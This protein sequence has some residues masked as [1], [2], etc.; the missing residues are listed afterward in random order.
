MPPT[1]ALTQTKRPGVLIV[2]ERRERDRLN[3]WLA[4]YASTYGIPM[5]DYHTFLNEG[6]PL[7]FFMYQ[8]LTPAQKEAETNRVD[9]TVAADPTDTMVEKDAYAWH[10]HVRAWNLEQRRCRREAEDE[11]IRPAETVLKRCIYL[12]GYHAAPG[13]RQ[14]CAAF[15]R[16]ATDGDISFRTRGNKEIC[17]LPWSGILGIE[18]LPPEN[19]PPRPRWRFTRLIARRRQALLSIATASGNARF[20]VEGHES[21]E[22][23]HALANLI[24]CL[25]QP[26]ADTYN[27]R[28]SFYACIGGTTSSEQYDPF[29]AA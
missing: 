28:R 24:A 20:V 16:I 23:K 6:R 12:G 19:P 26:T 9:E 25:G 15:V 4:G 29:P 22:L 17:S 5:R 14:L 8:Q 13:C 7:F 11:A 1:A 10:Y 27:E 3:A 21:N 2:W 18:V